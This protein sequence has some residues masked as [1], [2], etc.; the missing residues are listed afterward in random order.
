VIVSSKFNS[1]SITGQT[2]FN[3]L[4]DQAMVGATATGGPAELTRV[5]RDR[6]AQVLRIRI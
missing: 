6:V 3:R 4:F 5:V 2:D 1:E